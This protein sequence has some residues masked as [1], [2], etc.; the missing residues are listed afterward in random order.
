MKVLNTGRR[1]WKSRL[2]TAVMAAMV[3]A[4]LLPLVSVSWSLLA[5]GW[6]PLTSYFFTHLPIDSPPGVGNAILGTMLIL[7]FAALMAVPFGLLVGIYLAHRGTT[8]LA[9][10]TR[11]TLDVMSGIPALVVGM[12]VYTLVVRQFGFS[13]LAGSLSLALIMLPIFARTTEEA[14]KAIP[15]TV[16][17]AGLALGL[18]RRRVILRIVLRSAMPSVLTGLFLALARVG[19]EAAPLLF[20]SSGS[21]YWPAHSAKAIA[22]LE[23]LRQQSASLPYLIYEY[24]KNPDPAMVSLA[25][26]AS[27]LLVAMILCVRLSTNLFIRRRYGRQGSAH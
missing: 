4:S 10:T 5:K 18:P 21:F 3:L 13:L 17:E 9:H 24:A 20:T 6:A 15:I 7:L 1:R 2:A 16:N 8:R 11:T 26:G 27:L 12:F 25:W 22:T 23:P 19:G 14:V